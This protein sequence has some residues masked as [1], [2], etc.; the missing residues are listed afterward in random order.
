VP[1]ELQGRVFSAR[2][3]IAQFASIIPMVL[4]GPL[5]DKVLY[6]YFTRD[7]FLTQIFGVGK[8]SSIGFLAF[9]AGMITILVAIFGFLNP[10]VVNV[11][12]I[13]FEDKKE[14]AV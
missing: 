11:E 12:Q 6:N 9:L 13:N 2:R 4:S 5:V 10:L 8:G 7:N 14:V 1:I 3:F